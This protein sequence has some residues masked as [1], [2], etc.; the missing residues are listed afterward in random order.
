[1]T[2]RPTK[3]LG[4]ALALPLALLLWAGLAGVVLLAIY[5]VYGAI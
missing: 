3:K 2:I 5:L 1:V 4:C